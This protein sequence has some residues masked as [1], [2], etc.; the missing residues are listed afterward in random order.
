M[1][2]K[3]RRLIVRFWEIAG[4][5]NVR[6]KIMGIVLGGTL[7]LSLVLTYQAHHAL[8]V[9][10]ERDLLAQGV[11]LG[12]NLAARSTD[13]ILINDT[14]ALDQL[15]MET[16][17]N[18]S[19]LRYAFVIDLQGNVIAHTFGNGFPVGLLDLNQ[20]ASG[21]YQNTI[22]LQTR[23]GLVWDIAVPIFE[24]R[25]GIVRVGISNQRLQSA[26][27]DLTSQ[28]LLATAIVLGLS[29]LAATFLTFI[30]TR[31]ILELVE[32]TRSIGRGDFSHRLRRWANDEI[33]DL[34]EAFNQMST[35]LGKADEVRR[36]R[37]LLRRQLL[38]RVIAAQEEER[39]RIARELHDSTS[40]SLTSLM[41]GLRALESD[42][43]SPKVRQH[44][45]EL[46]RVAGQVLEDVHTLAVQ[47]RPA[48]LDDLGL[49]AA[50]N[51]L[52][53][54][55]Q[56]RHSIETSVI[57]HLGN[58]RLTDPLETALYR[59]IQE[60]LTNVA[61]HAQAKSVNVLV[62]RR[63]TDIVAVIEDH[64]RGFNL[65]QAHRD[66]HLGLLG[67]RERAESLGGSL[68]IESSPGLGTSLYIQLPLAV[69]AIQ[70]VEGLTN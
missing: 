10:M 63:Q 11:S 24:G 44:S 28:V 50:L 14:Y 43:D 39:R 19:D 65:E 33:G 29:L 61:K 55:W 13:L 37:E 21:A 4:G 68:T 64:G 62:E 15:L 66:G 8:S 31:P 41:V 23:E 52:A 46:R 16:Q 38:E 60:A 42:C 3:W 70:E 67:I 53:K 49:S 56:K 58:E 26:L 57:V 59:S 12:R 7:L 40:Q 1:N 6:V 20:V 54:E 27:S 51:R 45:G 30:L 9:I 36:E 5:V 47:L 34:T 25:A 18:N 22:S 35:E 32:A 69:Q 17:K 2:T 48:V